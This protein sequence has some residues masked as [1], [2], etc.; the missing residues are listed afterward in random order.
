[1]GPSP[2]L[3]PTV[4]TSPQRRNESRQGVRSEDSS[5]DRESNPSP[6]ARPRASRAAAGDNFLSI[7]KLQMIQDKEDQKQ[8]QLI[9]AEERKETMRMESNRREERIEDRRTMERMF[10]MAV[11]GFAASQN[12]SSKKKKRAR[13][14][15]EYLSSLESESDEELSI[16]EVT[17]FNRKDNRK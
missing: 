5:T 4:T 3:R 11:G 8:D 16:E 9:R 15:V 14:T 12:K 6:V 10:M 1:M 13:R 7:M 17:P 2:N